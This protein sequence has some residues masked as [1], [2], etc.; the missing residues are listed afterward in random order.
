MFALTEKVIHLAERDKVI[1]H[2][3]EELREYLVRVNL[4]DKLIQY[5]RGRVDF[6]VGRVFEVCHY[7]QK[8]EGHHEQ[9]A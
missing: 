9:Q 2:S 6:M 8:V 3:P 1:F 7:W 4:M 5:A